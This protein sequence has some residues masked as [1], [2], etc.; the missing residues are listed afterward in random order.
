MMV[1]TDWL[2]TLVS[3]C[4]IPDPPHPRMQICCEMAQLVSLPNT[5]QQRSIWA[6]ARQAAKYIL[7]PSPV[8]LCATVDA[9]IAQKNCCNRRIGCNM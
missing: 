3:E 9:T 6:R 8:L 4:W 1:P 2:Y 5:A 7:Q